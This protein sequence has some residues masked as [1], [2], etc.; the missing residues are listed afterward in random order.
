M[1][2]DVQKWLT[3]NMQALGLSEEER[4]LAAKLSSGEFGKR[5]GASIYPQEAVSGL[6]SALDR[7]GAEKRQL[8]EANVAWQEQYWK[9]LAELGA[10]DRLQAAG[11]DTTG[12]TATRSGGIQTQQG[13]QLTA[14]QIDEMIERKA[15]EIAFGTMDP[16]RKL[17]LDYSDF[18]VT[19]APEYYDLTGKRLDAKKFREFTAEHSKEFSTLQQA[20][21]SFTADARAAKREADQKKWE[22]DKER[23]I[24]LRVMSRMQ[25]PEVSPESGV[26]GPFD[27]A[28]KAPVA[29]SGDQQSTTQPTREV[30][31][32]EFAKKYR[33]LDLSGL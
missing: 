4:A 14:Q 23:E 7:Q 24:E 17:Q 8:E 30:N 5:L 31:R 26:G 2:V 12:L 16:M 33:D 22:S 29:A 15:R 25:I 3:D 18:L 28:S 32:Q 11:F 27:I 6:Q 20:F 9:D 10:V 21:D 19:A 1:A 13:Q